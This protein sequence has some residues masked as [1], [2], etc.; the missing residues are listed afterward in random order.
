MWTENI[1][2]R[3]LRVKL[4]LIPLSTGFSTLSLNPTYTERC[5]VTPEEISEVPATDIEL[6]CYVEQKEDNCLWSEGGPPWGGKDLW[7]TQGPI[8]ALGSQYTRRDHLGNT[9]AVL[10]RWS[11][12]SLPSMQRCI[13]SE[14]TESMIFRSQNTLALKLK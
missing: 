3:A 8:G 4:K 6:F 2:P 5:C 12:N 10:L 14:F 1:I 13:A 9:Q 11:A 7:N